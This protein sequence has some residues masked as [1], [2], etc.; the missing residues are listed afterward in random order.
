ML[1]FCTKTSLFRR[2][3]NSRKLRLGAARDHVLCLQ[4]STIPFSLQG[5]KNGCLW[6]MG[7]LCTASCSRL[8]VEIL[9]ASRAS[10]WP[11]ISVSLGSTSSH[12]GVIHKAK[13]VKIRITVEPHIKLSSYQYDQSDEILSPHTHT[14]H[15]FR[16]PITSPRILERDITT[17]FRHHVPQLQAIAALS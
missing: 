14:H 16:L 3:L 15:L 8:L 7:C 9:F 5:K 2:P 10:A 1:D 13:K 12:S 17:H 11:E 4:A 6:S